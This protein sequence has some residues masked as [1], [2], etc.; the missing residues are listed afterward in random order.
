MAETCADLAGDKTVEVA[1]AEVGMA[2]GALG[3]A[4]SWATAARLET[5]ATAA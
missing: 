3:K 1:Q 5:V 4:A 2:E